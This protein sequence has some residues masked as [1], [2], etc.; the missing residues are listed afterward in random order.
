LSDLAFDNDAAAA[1][2]EAGGGFDNMVAGN[3]PPAVE[4][5]APAETPAATPEVSTPT[6]SATPPNSVTLY[7]DAQGRFTTEPPAP[8]E[9]AAPEADTESFWDG[10]INSLPPELQKVYREQLQPAWTKKTQELAELRKQYEPLTALGEVDPAQ[11]QQALELYNQLS[12]PTAWQALHA[13][14]SAGLQSLG[15]SPA[16]ADAA[17]QEKLEETARTPSA[18]P[19][20]GLDDEELAPVKSAFESMQ[21]R[22]EQLESQLS[23]QAA[24]QE[25]ERLRQAVVGEMQRQEDVIR[26]AN[27][28][29]TE[30]DWDA[31]YEIAQA[32]GY[33]GNLLDAQQRYESIVNG[34]IE[35][36][37]A[38][39]SGL[40]TAAQPTPGAQTITVPV[41]EAGAD[42]DAAKEAALRWA[43]EFDQ[44]NAL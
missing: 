13:E 33:Q 21:S 27:P 20:D 24:A 7:R 43:Q 22:L 11:V 10:D 16:Q 5:P 40:T 36:Y 1:A 41:P 14:L 18:T 6:P 3:E 9:P 28:S 31:I 4:A 2:I 29:Y 37:F 26:A 17:A 44:Q 23:N 30:D 19:L 25:Q 12:D 39:K 32:T 38:Q 8:G 42:F 35:R 15:L 34:R